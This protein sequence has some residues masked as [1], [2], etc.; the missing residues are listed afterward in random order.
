MALRRNSD[1]GEPL[2]N[3][4]GDEKLASE[5]AALADNLHEVIER[6]TRYGA[7]DAPT[8]EIH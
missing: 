1:Q 2:K 4:D 3:F 6:R 5:L 7:D 8:L